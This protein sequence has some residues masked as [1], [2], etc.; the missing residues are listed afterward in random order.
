M[1]SGDMLETHDTGVLFH[2]FT[3]PTLSFW[4]MYITLDKPTH[5]PEQTRYTEDDVDAVVKKYSKVHVT[6]D[7]LFEDMWKAR[8][9]HKLAS[10]EEGVQKRWYWKR[11]VLL[12]DSA[13]KV[14]AAALPTLTL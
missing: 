14:R 6:R 11:I 7:V 2:I 13:H 12:G 10:L 9:R 3:Q 8:S 4:F 1:K 5:W